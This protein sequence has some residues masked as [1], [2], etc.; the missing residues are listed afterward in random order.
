M[1]RFG[2]ESQAEPKKWKDPDLYIQVD[3]RDFQRA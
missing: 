3:V 1:E 2:M